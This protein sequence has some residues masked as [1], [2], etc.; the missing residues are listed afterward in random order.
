MILSKNLEFP[1]EQYEKFI[2]SSVRKFQLL[3]IVGE[4]GSGKTTIVPQLLYKN[5]I[6]DKIIVSQTKRIAAINAANY[7]SKIL[8]L[9]VGREVGYA[10]RFENNSI[11]DTKIKFVTD[12]ILFKELSENPSL[13]HYNCVIIDEFHE[14][15]IYTDLLL[16]ILKTILDERE[17]FRLVIMSASGEC[18]K[19]AT[20]FNMKAGKLTIPGRLFHIKIFYT[21]N[22][23]SNYVLSISAFIFK[24]HLKESIPGNFLVFLPGQEEIQKLKEQIDYVIGG[25]ISNFIVITFY[26][27]ISEEECLNVFKISQKKKRKIILAT[28]I[29]ESSITIPEISLV[30]DSGLSKQK[31]TNWKNGIDLFRIYPISKSEAQ[32]RAGRAGRER[33]GKCYRMYTFKDFC[34][35]RSYPKPEIQR[36]DLTSII[37]MLYSFKPKYFLSLDFITIPPI[38]S[39]YRSFEKLFILGIITRKLRIT[40]LGKLCSTFPLEINM[41][42]AII[43]ALKK[44]NRTL[45][46]LILAAISVLSTNMTIFTK[47]NNLFLSNNY[48]KLKHLGDQFCYAIIFYKYQLKKKNQ[49]AK[50]WCKKK[51]LNQNCL[52]LAYSI[53]IQIKDICFTIAPLL[54][55]EVLEI[56]KI[57]P[58]LSSQFRFCFTAGYFLNAAR[59][60]IYSKKYQSICS[61]L[62]T[63]IYPISL[64]KYIYPKIIIFHEFFITSKPFI[65]GILPTRLEWLIL[66]GKKIF[67]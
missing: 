2:L 1:V 39:I 13:S 51:N 30:I 58:D 55:S 29:A 15:T 16:S 46:N 60:S 22:P 41:S 32:Q 40:F 45:L 66:F 54:K 57:Q 5:R 59:F 28:N 49:K 11:F 35:F 34:S 56:N 4:T 31:I 6:F 9:K 14:R 25:K 3:M 27:G 48:D 26:S 17:N 61:G 24:Y 8:N 62:L 18:D 52:N 64:Y 36:A 50:N 47:R 37:V 42:M 63:E 19:M 53:K 23:Q 12:G 44:K 33:N 20:F 43:E 38:W 21:I 7:I 67:I 65:R 10:V